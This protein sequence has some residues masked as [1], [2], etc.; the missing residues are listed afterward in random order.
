MLTRLNIYHHPSDDLQLIAFLVVKI[1]WWDLRESFSPPW[2]LSTLSIEATPILQRWTIL[3]IIRG[4]SVHAVKNSMLFLRSL[5]LIFASS[6]LFF[7]HIKMTSYDPYINRGAPLGGG[8]TVI[9]THTHLHTVNSPAIQS[10]RETQHQF[11]F[12]KYLF[13]RRFEI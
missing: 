13:G 6:F 2:E 9:A 5:L 11:I 12:G 3:K 7:F 1:S 4:A 10:T 8:V